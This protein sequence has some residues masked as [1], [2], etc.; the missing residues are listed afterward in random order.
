VS[1][2]RMP[3]I[4]MTKLGEEQTRV[5]SVQYWQAEIGQMQNSFTY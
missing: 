4:L 5:T 1:E 3:M 2:K